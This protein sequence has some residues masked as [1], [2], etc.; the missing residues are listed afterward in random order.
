MSEDWDAKSLLHRNRVAM[1]MA[2]ADALD[3]GLSH[4]ISRFHLLHG[5]QSAVE[6]FELAHAGFGSLFLGYIAFWGF[7]CRE[8]RY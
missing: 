2:K 5:S 1:G 3:D 8:L 6:C 7:D 4:L